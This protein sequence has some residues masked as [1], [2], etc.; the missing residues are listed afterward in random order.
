MKRL[1]NGI[2]L[3]SKEDTVR[4]LTEA[5]N[6]NFRL[7]LYFLSSS[8]QTITTNTAVTPNS[9]VTGEKL[10]VYNG[11]INITGVE[12]VNSVFNPVGFYV[13]DKSVVVNDPSLDELRVLINLAGNPS[14]LKIREWLTIVSGFLSK[15]IIGTELSVLN[16][17]CQPN[18]EL[19]FIKCRS[20]I[21]RASVSLSAIDIK[22]EEI[23]AKEQ[24]IK[25]IKDYLVQYKEEFL[26]HVH[27]ASDIKTG[28]I[29]PD[30]LAIGFGNISNY[31][32]GNK[33][34]GAS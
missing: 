9:I 23:R 24:R 6:N 29:E 3:V 10:S 30:L 33:T 1:K 17:V 14:G 7:T 13:T 21:T 26:D 5:F 8:P 25:E 31:L 15:Y 32:K 2:L 20:K 27:D 12:F 34:W 19:D 22:A 28:K 11:S 18:N 16:W 4:D